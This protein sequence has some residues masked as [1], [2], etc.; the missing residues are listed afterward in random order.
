V[1]FSFTCIVKHQ[2]NYVAVIPEQEMS[3]VA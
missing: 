2:S 1:F 3:F